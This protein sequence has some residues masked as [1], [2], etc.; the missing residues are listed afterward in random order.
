LGLHGKNG[1]PIAFNLNPWNCQFVSSW[2]SDMGI[3]RDKIDHLLYSFLVRSSSET[4][5][6][7]RADL[8]GFSAYLGTDSIAIAVG[9]LLDSPPG[10]ACLTVLHY[11][12]I[13]RD[14]GLKP[15][16]CN[17]KIATLRSLVRSANALG[18]ITWQ[19]DIRNDKMRR[20]TL[21]KPQMSD[22]WRLLTCSQQQPKPAKSAR[23]YAILR[24]ILDLGLKRGVVAGLDMTDVDWQKSRLTVRVDNRTT[25]THLDLPIRTVKALRHWMDHRDPVDGPLFVNFDRARKGAR[26]TPNS[27]YRIVRQLGKKAGIEIGPDRVRSA[28]VIANQG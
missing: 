5:R 7:Y 19:L 17:R 9:L 8:D 10:Q 27:I 21:P 28:A 1:E 18:L 22:L 6:S 11:R 3:D 12:S 4:R 23:D 14:R 24:L 13:L 16:T 26:L 2:K 15:A 20:N 25:A